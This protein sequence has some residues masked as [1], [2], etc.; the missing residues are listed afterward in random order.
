MLS[1]EIPIRGGEALVTDHWFMVT[2]TVNG[3]RA[4]PIAISPGTPDEELMLVSAAA[5]VAGIISSA[6]LD[7][8]RVNGQARVLVMVAEELIDRRAE[9][10]K[11]ENRGAEK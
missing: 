8:N 7:D 2:P 6:T 5:P 11:A 9:H 4:A 10:K 1:V 3:M